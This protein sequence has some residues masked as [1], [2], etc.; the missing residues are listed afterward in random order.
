[1]IKFGFVF[2][3]LLAGS[4]L[5]GLIAHRAGED[6]RPDSGPAQ[7]AR[8][9]A[10]NGLVLYVLLVAIAA[11]VLDLRQFLGAHYVVGFLLIPPLI[12]KF[13]STGYRLLRYYTGNTDY[14][15]A[16]VPPLVLRFLVAPALVVSTVVV[17][18]TGLELW[19]FG[20]RF[21]SAWISAHTLSAVVM[22]AAV[23][24]H[25][26][27]HFGRSVDVARAEIGGPREKAFTRRSLVA[28]SLVAGAV[29]AV[30]SL[31]YVSPFTT[32]VGG[33]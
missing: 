3:L 33:T 23:A 5:W 13:G 6:P 18:V 7:N 32:S 12:V 27:A 10:L 17:F 8:L 14:R 19:L 24:V 29:L 20:L 22:V 15:L 11:T 1:M 9:T 16:G 30:A 2:L 26:A 31:L 21:G 4:A 28:A 25:S